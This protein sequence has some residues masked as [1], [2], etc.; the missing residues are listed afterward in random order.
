MELTVG[1]T[2]EN[3]E[4][5]DHPNHPTPCNHSEQPSNQLATL[6]QTL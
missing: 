2:K 6:P 3:K 1:I 4:V 5:A